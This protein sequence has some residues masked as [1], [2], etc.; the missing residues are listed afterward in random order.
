MSDNKKNEFDNRIRENLYFLKKN[1]KYESYVNILNKWVLENENNFYKL[2]ESNKLLNLLK[3][4]TSTKNEIVFVE[5]ITDIHYK[6][7]DGYYSIYYWI[8][9]YKELFNEE[10]VKCAVTLFKGLTVVPKPLAFSNVSDVMAFVSVAPNHFDVFP[11]SIKEKAKSIKYSLPVDYN[12]TYNEECAAP[13]HKHHIFAKSLFPTEQRIENSVEIK[14][15]LVIK[16]S[17]KQH[18][19]L[20]MSLKNGLQSYED[21]II[22]LIESEEESEEIRKLNIKQTY[23]DRINQL[24]I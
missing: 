6:N 12:V 18:D 2:V 8:I 10:I 5:N 4:G 20:H 13:F 15:E 11:L 16:L 23:E 9:E 24:I 1:N 19:E 21:K 7:R 17:K 22:E 14:N 3:K